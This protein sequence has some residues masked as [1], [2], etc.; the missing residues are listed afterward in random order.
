VMQDWKA[1]GKKAACLS[2]VDAFVMHV[3]KNVQGGEVLLV[4]S[5]GGFGG[6]R[7]KLP[8]RPRRNQTGLLVHD[9]TNYFRA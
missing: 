7:R 4:F 9:R 5:N 2:D 1:A 6:I 8:E 3:S